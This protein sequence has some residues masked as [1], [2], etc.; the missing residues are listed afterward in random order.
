[1]EKAFAG[2]Y[3]IATRMGGTSTCRRSRRSRSLSFVTVCAEKPAVHRFP[4]SMGKRVHEVAQRLSR[5]H[6]GDAVHLWA[7]VSDGAEL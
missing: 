1:M 4:G 3:V 7:S 2:P 5:G 6:D